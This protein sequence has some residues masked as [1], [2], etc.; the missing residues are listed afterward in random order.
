[1]K[2]SKLL[3]E[4]QGSSRRATLNISAFDLINTMDKVEQMGIPV[5]RYDGPTPDGKTYLEYT[6]YPEG[7]D[8]D[9][10]DQAFT[11]YD[12]KFG[13]DPTDEENYMKEYPF[14]VGARARVGIVNASNLGLE[15]SGM[16]EEVEEDKE[17]MISKDQMDKLHKGDPIK[18]GDTKVLFKVNESEVIKEELGPT[19][20]AISKEQIRDLIKKG[21]TMIKIFVQDKDGTNVRE[22]DYAISNTSYKKNPD[23]IDIPS[24]NEMGPTTMDEGVEWFKKIAGVK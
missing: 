21:S 20:I 17:V 7:K 15:I 16:R 9:K 14:S 24:D 8:E 2:L 3:N 12:Y 10:L 23:D 19:G 11:V 18:I 13:E 6:V 1:M 5:D 22:V 4:L